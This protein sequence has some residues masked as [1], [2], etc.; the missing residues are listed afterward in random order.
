MEESKTAP[1]KPMG[2]AP[3]GAKVVVGKDGISNVKVEVQ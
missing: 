1:I 2:A 3:S